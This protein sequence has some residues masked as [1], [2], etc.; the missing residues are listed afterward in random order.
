[1]TE[2]ELVELACN[3]ILYIMVSIKNGN[4]FPKHNKS[5]LKNFKLDCQFRLFLTNICCTK[6]YFCFKNN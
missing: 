5:H 1:M 6:K 3:K 4:N 2:I